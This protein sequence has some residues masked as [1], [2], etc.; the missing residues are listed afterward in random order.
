MKEIF[1]VVV[2]DVMNISGRILPSYFWISP[3]G[4]SF[5]LLVLFYFFFLFLLFPI[6]V[7]IFF[8]SF[9]LL[10]FINTIWLCFL[11]FHCLS[12]FGRDLCCFFK[13]LIVTI[14]WKSTSVQGWQICNVTLCSSREDSLSRS[15]QFS[16][17]WPQQSPQAVNAN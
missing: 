3:I 9:C 7:L 15:E 6:F 4:F 1:P 8:P 12:Y 5:L 13:P 16:Q 10:P 2:T 14:I 17:I 11:C